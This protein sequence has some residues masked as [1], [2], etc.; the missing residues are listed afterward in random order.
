[1][2][3]ITIIVLALGI[4]LLLAEPAIP[5]FF[6]SVVGV[7]LLVLGGFAMI[8]PAYIFE[9]TAIIA[10]FIAS[11]FTLGTMVMV[12]RKYGGGAPPE[13]AVA[14]SLVGKKGIVKERVIPHSLDGK[15]E[16]NNSMWSATADTEIEVGTPVVVVASEGVHVT[17]KPL[18]ENKENT[19][20]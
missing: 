4:I 7:F 1:M 15:V 5:G 8:D 2:D 12:Y 17:V 11:L 6:L 13:T 18:T 10:A 3:T 20:R 16:I 19:R 14:S 9:P